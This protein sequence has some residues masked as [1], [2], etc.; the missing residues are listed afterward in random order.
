MVG[1]IFKSDVFEWARDLAIIHRIFGTDHARP[2]AADAAEPVRVV[3]FPDP[4]GRPE[5]AEAQPEAQ[6]PHIAEPT[7]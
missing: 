7:R 5:R 1:S 4:R 2:H 3:P 6:P